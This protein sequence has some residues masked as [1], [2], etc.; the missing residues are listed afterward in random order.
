M[1]SDAHGE[2]AR[3]LENVEFAAGVPQLLKGGFS[4]QAGT[5][6]GRVLDPSAARRRC[7][8]HAVQLPGDGAAVDGGERHRVRQH[9]RAQAVARRTRRP[10]LWLAAEVEAGGAAG[11]R[12]QRA[13]RATRRRSTP[14][15]PTP[16]SRPR[17]A[18]SAPRRSRATS[19]RPAPSHGK[20]VQ[21]LGGA[22]NHMVVL[23]DA[24]IDLAADAAVSPPR[25]APPASGACRSRWPSRSGDAGDRLVDA[26]RRRG[27]PSCV[28]ATATDAD[29]EMGPLITA[30]H[31]DKVAGYIAAGAESGAT[32]VVD[33]REAGRAVRRASSS[34]PRCWTTSPRDMSVYT[35]EIFG[36]VLS[37]VRARTPTTRRSS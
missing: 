21:A 22:K 13:C 32:V 25:T 9:V 20:R 10:S 18:S 29:S 4:E 19:T 3:A 33:G 35:D 31:R 27:C 6:R 37:V 2:I 36:P 7:R 24:D 28:S 5:G 34:A 30:E 16:M 14:C 12:V 1:L 15:S 23:P 8:H 26:V 11:R 17:S